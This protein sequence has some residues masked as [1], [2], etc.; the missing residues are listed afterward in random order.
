M[1]P[2]RVI[3]L[4]LGGVLAVAGTSAWAYSGRPEHKR[5]CPDQNDDPRVSQRT[6][7]FQ[8]LTARERERAAQIA[9][10]DPI[11]SELLAGEVPRPNPPGFGDKPGYSVLSRAFPIDETRSTVWVNVTLEKPISVG[12][13]KWRLFNSKYHNDCFHDGLAWMTTQVL[14]GDGAGTATGG[15]NPI[16]TSQLMLQVSL[17]GGRVVMVMPNTYDPAHY[18]PVGEPEYLYRSNP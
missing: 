15:K 9:L 18:R 13:H 12:P 1:R 11:V 16:P 5:P 7:P 14:E 2:N 8:R 17:P 10:T 4:A 3:T 6:T